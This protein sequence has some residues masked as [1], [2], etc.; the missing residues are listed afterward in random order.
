[1]RASPCPFRY[2][3]PAILRHKFVALR[4]VP[5]DAY[6][7]SAQLDIHP[8]PDVITR[9]FMLFGGVHESQLSY[10][11]EAQGRAKEEVSRWNSIVGTV[12]QRQGDGTLSRVLEWGGMEIHV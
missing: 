5:Q 1:M 7:K 4:F 8:K 12:K 2:W 3:L 9:I 10:W 6:E 11:A